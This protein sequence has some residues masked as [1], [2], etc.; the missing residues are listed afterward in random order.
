VIHKVYKEIDSKVENLLA[1]LKIEDLIVFECY[2]HLYFSCMSLLLGLW[3]VYNWV[4]QVWEGHWHHW[5]NSTDEHQIYD[6]VCPQCFGYSNYCR[7]G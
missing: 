5:C 1:K 7:F 6:L 3:F 4:L 2:I